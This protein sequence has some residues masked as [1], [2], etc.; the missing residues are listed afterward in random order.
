M[1]VRL[2]QRHF[3]LT[4]AA[5]LLLAILHTLWATSLDS[6]TIDEPYH[7]TAGAT[8]L[9]WG[10]YRIN[11]EHP[12]LV[13]LVAALAEPA[14]VLHIAPFTPLNDKYQERVYTQTAVFTASD[15]HRV[16]R[17]ARFAMIVFH[18]LLLGL[19][20]WL[21]RRVFSAAMALATLLFLALDPTVSAHMPV[22]MTDLPVALLGTI[23]CCLT[24]LALRCRRWLDW[25]LLG[26]GIGLLLGTKHSA[27]LIVLPLLTG[28]LAVL[29]W[30]T[31]Q[32]HRADGP[33][34][35]ERL[36]VAAVLAMAVLWSLYGFRF[37]E[38][39]ERDAK[40]GYV[41]T[42]NRPLDAKIHDLRSPVLRGALTTATRLRLVPR[43]Y[44]WGLAD[45]LRAGVE[46]RPSLIRAFGRDY[47]DHA[48]WWIPFADLFVKLPLPF[49]ALA[50]AGIVMYAARKVP[51]KIARP[52][53]VFFAMLIVFLTFIAKNGIFYAGLR[54]WL[55]AVPL[56]AIFAACAAVACLEHPGRFIRAIPLAALLLIALPTLPQRRIWE[57]HNIL[58][59]GSGNAW[60]YFDNES[61]D[62][63]QRSDEIAA[64][65]KANMAPVDPLYG[66]WTVR[67]QLKAQGVREWEPTP[68]QVA[69]GYVTG[70]F[71][72]RAPW[73]PAQNWKHIE[74]FRNVTPVARVGNVF[75]YKG[76]FYLPFMAGGVINRQA[77]RLLQ[78]KDGD[79]A[80]A[81]AYFKRGVQLDPEA[82]GAFIELGNFAL[83]RKDKSGALTHYRAAVNA[84]KDS[85]TVRQAI[86]DYI[87]TVEAHPVG[88]VPPMR[89]PSL[90]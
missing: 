18:T 73:L 46:G 77:F 20:T 60:R 4:T 88:E 26:L 90:E 49:L 35:F 75:F 43:A 62:L 63:G 84:E 42:Y 38:S 64:F 56:L 70:W 8:Y 71:V 67:E 11:P 76:R 32:R 82:T 3:L 85:E 50:I 6:F 39:R 33:R 12:P 41:E 48:P 45:T 31:F 15:Y 72:S 86:R 25:L 55:F 34:Q 36:F 80:K 5:L 78:E 27:P 7:I 65:Y 54:H 47:I 30:Q 51:G 52:L 24:V 74:I 21:L 89:R 1:P 13:K 2:G 66:Y 44:L 9:R 28:S 87:K 83:L 58:A 29:L 40:G 10:D 16:Q 23:C 14:S 68:E 79:R 17:R 57:Y 19:L 59:G 61:I 69:D 22:V 53:S 81:E 37:H